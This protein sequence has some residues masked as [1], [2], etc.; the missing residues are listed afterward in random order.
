MVGAI[1]LLQHAIG[2]LENVVELSTSQLQSSPLS[3]ANASPGSIPSDADALPAYQSQ[4]V[5]SFLHRSTGNEVL[6]LPTG[7]GEC[8]VTDAIAAGM[9]ERHPSKHI[10][11]C[12]VRPAQALSHADRLRAALGVPVGAFCG[13]DF[14]YDFE[15]Q[16]KRNR[17]LV[18]TAGLL[19]RLTKLG[20]YRL[21]S[22]SLLVL[23]DAFSA[24]RNH[25]MNT[26]VREYYWKGPGG[27]IGVERPRVSEFLLLLNFLKI[28]LRCAKYYTHRVVE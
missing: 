15:E 24:V 18:F 26:L 9:L 23:H 22:A 25:P 1:E 10:V 5:D 6:F 27:E 19:M 21:S 8:A 20:T 7:L 14:L 28:A 4:L 2:A 13:G 3:P 11:V 12:V 16:F 17:V